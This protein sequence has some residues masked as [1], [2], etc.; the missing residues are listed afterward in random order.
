[1]PLFEGVPFA[2]F[3]STNGVTKRM[4][5]ERVFVG[6]R[7]MNDLATHRATSALHR[8]VTRGALHSF[9]RNP[10]QVFE[11]NVHRLL[12]TEVAWRV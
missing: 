4:R 8:Q 1:M 11:R 10:F 3:V 9:G 2:V 5:C 7:R 6:P 12:P